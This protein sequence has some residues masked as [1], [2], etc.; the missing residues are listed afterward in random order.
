M[1]SSSPKYGALG[2]HN[3]MPR[4]P[5]HRGSNIPSPLNPARRARA[6]THTGRREKESAPQP[7]DPTLYDLN[8]PLAQPDEFGQ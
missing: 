7:F 1:E 5:S 4:T 2:I 8:N 6:G 3:P